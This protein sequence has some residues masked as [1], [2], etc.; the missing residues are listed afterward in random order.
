M[1]FEAG[2]FLFHRFEIDFVLFLEGIDVARDVE[3]EVIVGEFLRGG[4]VGVFIDGFEGAVGG[5]DLGE[6][7]AGENGVRP[8]GWP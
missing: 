8:D 4:A 3:V 7:L 2:D 6:M 5:G 1:G